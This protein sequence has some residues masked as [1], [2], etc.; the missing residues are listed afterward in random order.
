MRFDERELAVAS[1]YGSATLALA[2]RDGRA[3]QLVEELNGLARLLDRDPAIERT[4]ASPM[5]EAEAR[6]GLVEKAF[7]GR[8]S[9][10]LVNALQVMN[11]KGRLGLIRA[12]VESCRRQYEAM[13]GI[14]EVE[15][16]TARK[17]SEAQRHDTEEVAA[18][19]V[20]G[21]VRLVE[22]VDPEIVGGMVLKTG[23]RK[24]DRTVARA[25]EGMGDRLRERASQQVQSLAA[26]EAGA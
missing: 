21:R 22:K 24:L 17:L 12:F 2:D 7:R 16:V 3:E 26:G 15:I 14:T 19:W 5:V 10:L 25:L 20:G 18:S 11:R 1:L 6:R 8:F 4:L 23:D 9:D 13:Q